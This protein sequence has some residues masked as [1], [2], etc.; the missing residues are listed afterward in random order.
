MRHD[1]TEVQTVATTARGFFKRQ[2]RD[3][4]STYWSTPDAPDWITDL[5]REAHNGM[6]PDDHKYEYIVD[7]LDL[8]TEAS[9]DADLDEAGYEIE[10]D[11]YTSDLMTWLASSN[12]RPGYVDEAVQEFGGEPGTLIDQVMLGQAYER[13]AVYTS[14]LASLRER[15]DEATD[16]D[17]TEEAEPAV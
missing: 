9:D 1:T 12:H 8:I 7:A 2:T 16:E 17:E 3:S 11:C 4:G 10:A 13:R 5:C 14:V 6:L 15:A